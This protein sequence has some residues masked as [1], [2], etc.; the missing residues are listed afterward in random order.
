MG[1]GYKIS[2]RIFGTHGYRWEDEDYDDNDNDKQI[3]E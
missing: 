2:I 1:N 3:F